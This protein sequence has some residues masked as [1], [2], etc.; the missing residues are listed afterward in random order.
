MAKKAIYTDEIEQLI[1]EVKN[2]KPK[3][4]EKLEIDEIRKILEN[5][6]RILQHADYIRDEAKYNRENL[7]TKKVEVCNVV[8]ITSHMQSSAEKHCIAKLYPKS[9]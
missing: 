8:Y 1:G 7:I 3:N 2:F 9:R 4:E 5:Y 6:I